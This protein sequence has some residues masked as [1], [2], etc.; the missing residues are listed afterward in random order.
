MTRI[1]YLV[2]R[3]KAVSLN[4]SLIKILANNWYLYEHL[5]QEAFFKGLGLGDLTTNTFYFSI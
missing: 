4:I 3:F 2:C 1:N 5:L